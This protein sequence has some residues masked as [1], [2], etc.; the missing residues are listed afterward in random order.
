MGQDLIWLFIKLS[1]TID[2]N[3]PVC[4][5]YFINTTVTLT[6]TAKPSKDLTST[7]CL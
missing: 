7:A 2:Y 4:C 6:V 3:L 5:S 1:T